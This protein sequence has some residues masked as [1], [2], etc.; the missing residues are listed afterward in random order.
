[1]LTIINGT[2]KKPIASERLIKIFSAHKAELEGTLFIGYPII[3]TSRGH[4]S[5][6]ATYIS[7]SHGLVI[8]D[9]NETKVLDDNYK[10]NQD[11]SYSQ[12]KTK[13]LW[14]GQTS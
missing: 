3:G 14:L 10:K 6:D 13:V 9:L 2:N 12:F 8:F 4:H 11:D 7:E 5:F 1:M